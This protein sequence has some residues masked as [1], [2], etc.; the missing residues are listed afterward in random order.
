MSRPLTIAG[1]T[2]ELEWTQHTARLYVVRSAKLGLDPLAIMGQPAR[3]IYAIAAFFWLLL[4][5]AEH[6]KFAT[7][8]DLFAAMSE[9]EFD[10]PETVETLLGLFEDINPTPEKKSTSKNSPS[11]ALNSGSGRKNGKK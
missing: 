9:E 8:E 3:R 1:R 10:A 7:P 11:P 2:V 6:A 4:P 5:P